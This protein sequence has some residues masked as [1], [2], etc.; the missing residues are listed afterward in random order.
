[1]GHV[2]DLP[3]RSW[4]WTSRRGS[5]PSTRSSPPARRSSTSSRPRPRTRA[6]TIFLAADP[7][8]EGEAI[9]WHL[10]E[11]LGVRS[12]KKFKRVVF[13]EITKKA[14]DLAFQNPGEV[15]EKKVDAQQTRRILDPPR[16]LQGE[17]V[18]WEKVRRGLSAGRVQSVASSSSAT[19]SARSARSWPKSTGRWPRTWKPPSRRRSPRTSSRRTARTSRSRRRRGRRR[20][21]RPGGGQPS[22]SP[23]SRRRSGAAIRCRPSSPRSCSRKPSRSCATA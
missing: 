2:R 7:D 19:A 11:S 1:M 20:A 5:P 13:N 18:L 21:T 17:P 22:P 3:R 4:A 8:R 12:K 9:C 10:S 16:G 23:R 14:L 15:D 6:D